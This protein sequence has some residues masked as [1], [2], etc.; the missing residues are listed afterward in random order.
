MAFYV[1]EPKLHRF[2]LSKLAVKSLS[3]DRSLIQTD[4][5]PVSRPTANEMGVKMFRAEDGLTSEA[6]KYG[7]KCGIDFHGRHYSVTGFN[8]RYI[9]KPEPRPRC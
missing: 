3:S 5:N 8:R 2:F 6:E 1:T 4:S 9:C 7:V